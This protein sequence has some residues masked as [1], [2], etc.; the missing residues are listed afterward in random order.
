MQRILAQNGDF[1]EKFQSKSSFAQD[2]LESR[3]GDANNLQNQSRESLPEAFP[4]E[5]LE[6]LQK[7][8]LRY[9]QRSPD[10]EL[11]DLDDVEPSH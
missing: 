7:E 5:Q 6:L 9:Q 1:S 3:F 2:A 10:S 8:R 4:G 11:Q